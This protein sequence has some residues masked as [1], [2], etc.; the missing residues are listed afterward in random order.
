MKAHSTDPLPPDWF[1]R[2][3]LKF[4]HLQLFVALDDHRNLHR[5]AARLG[6]S[7]PAASKL[8]GDLEH[9]LGVSL[10]ERHSRGVT[11]NWYG[12]SLIRHARGMLTSLTQASDEINALKEGNAGTVSIGTVLAP[13]VTLLAS[14]VE[15][16][17]RD[18]PHLEVNIDVGVSRNLVP[19]LRDGEFDFAIAR[20]PS[21]MPA[22]DFV[23]EE[24][25]EEALCF[26]CRAGHPL[27]KDAFDL[28][29][30]LDYPW[31]LQPPG[32]LMRQ[33]VEH[34]FLHH[35]VA[36]PQRIINTPDIYMALAMV[37]KSDSITVTTREVAD[38]LCTQPRFAILPS[39][40]ALSVQ[41]FG[42]ISLRERR[43]SPGAAKLMSTLHQM[44]R[45][46][47]AHE[48]ST[49]LAHYSDVTL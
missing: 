25:G 17:H 30:M 9:L 13:A 27:A 4:R 37:D 5:A 15:S 11:P 49:T 39:T 7:Q 46:R 42:L 14:A 31:V 48:P 6:M 12:E 24:I 20:I 32:A 1:L 22:G 35:K 8:L 36:P 23:F 19:R 41:P 44:I 40:D 2:V 34:L 21:G 47:R 10:F 16:V 45:E 26:V 33:R 38:L 3:R 28:I 43:M 29:P 18:S